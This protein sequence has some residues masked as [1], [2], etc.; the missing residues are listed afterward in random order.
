MTTRGN[1]K[2]S[3]GKEEMAELMG[4]RGKWRDAE[5]RGKGEEK[6]KK[7]RSTS[8]DTKA[9]PSHAGGKRQIAQSAK[10]PNE[11][12]AKDRRGPPGHPRRWPSES[13]ARESG[14]TKAA[15]N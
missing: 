5:K 9:C 7:K 13:A 12:K 3:K 6:S 8:T 11:E 2:G 10:L 14:A 4:I 1:A 15:R